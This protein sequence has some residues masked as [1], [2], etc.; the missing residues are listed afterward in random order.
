MT[1]YDLDG[2]GFDEFG[3]DD[4][5]SMCKIPIIVAPDNNIYFVQ[6][7]A[8]ADSVMRLI[9]SE[10]TDKVIVTTLYS[11]KNSIVYSSLRTMTESFQQDHKLWVINEFGMQTS[12]DVTGSLFVSNEDEDVKIEFSRSMEGVDDFLVRLSE[13]AWCEAAM[14]PR[15]ITTHKVFSEEDRAQNW[16]ADTAQTLN[17]RSE[18]VYEHPSQGYSL[19]LG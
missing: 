2:D 7:T 10:K 12:L 4:D 9:I 17:I 18:N 5:T 13:H 15:S 6:H 14:Y 3:C 11:E 8:R 1:T 16:Q 19:A